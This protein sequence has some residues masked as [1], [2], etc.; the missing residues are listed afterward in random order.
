MAR[1]PNYHL[2]AISWPIGRSL[3][4]KT[5]RCVTIPHLCNV[6]AFLFLIQLINCH[7][8]RRALLEHH[9]K[10]FM[11]FWSDGE[12]CGTLEE[13][14]VI[15]ESECR[16][17]ES[18]DTFLQ[19]F[20][21]PERDLKFKTICDMLP[22]FDLSLF[23][24]QGF[25]LCLKDSDLDISIVRKLKDLHRAPVDV[26]GGDTDLVDIIRVSNDIC[27]SNLVSDQLHQ[28]S[29]VALRYA[30]FGSSNT[31]VA[32]MYKGNCSNSPI[33][34]LSNLASPIPSQR[35]FTSS[36]LAVLPSPFCDS[37]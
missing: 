1:T 13:T 16:V 27:S 32:G 34:A 15:K 37:C 31:A 25:N 8:K 30:R 24:S 9:Y 33:A 36:A 6:F 17:S 28:D 20:L 4:R 7:S 23:G 12:P 19:T 11:K 18:V 10:D 21:D 35:G 29:S 2:L 22:D 3:S 26:E 14:L 5:P